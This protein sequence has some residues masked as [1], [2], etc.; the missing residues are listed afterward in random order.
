MGRLALEKGHDVFI[1]ASRIIAAAN[2]NV[3]FAIAGGGPLRAELTRRIAATGLSERLQLLG[4]VDDPR[5]LLAELAVVVQP[6]DVES[7]SRVVLEAMMQARPIVAT[8]VGGTSTLLRHGVSGVLVPPRDPARIAAEVT[9]LLADPDR[10]ARMGENAR[11]A[12]SAEHSAEV[13]AD[14]VDDVYRGV[15][16][17]RA[18]RPSTWI[19]A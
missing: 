8:D 11:Q 3:R 16:G 17:G 9:E 1:D 5:A 12:A 14:G 13:M 4:V 10:A 7:T 19:R 2:P 6:S 18:E 15:L